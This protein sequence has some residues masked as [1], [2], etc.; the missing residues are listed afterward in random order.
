M[1]LTESDMHVFNRITHTHLT[2]SHMYALKD[3]MYAFNVITKVC[4]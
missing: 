2:G 1:H 4:I 3:H